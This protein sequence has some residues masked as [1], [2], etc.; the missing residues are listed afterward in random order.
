MG[1]EAK[2]IGKPGKPGK[3]GE[4]LAAKIEESAQ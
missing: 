2:A 1:A 4:R 3:P